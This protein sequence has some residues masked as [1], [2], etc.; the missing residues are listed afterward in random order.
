MSRELWR[1]T[2]SW[3]A[4]VA[5]SLRILRLLG[6]LP[7]P[8]IDV[9]APGVPHSF[10]PKVYAAAQPRSAQAG[11]PA[12]H[13]KDAA[14]GTKYHI[15]DK[16]WCWHCPQLHLVGLSCC[17]AIVLCL[18][19][20]RCLPPKCHCHYLPAPCTERIPHIKMYW[21]LARCSPASASIVGK[22][23]RLGSHCLFTA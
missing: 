3:D 19:A 9:H 7:C 2:L 14:G 5:L 18:N 11:I 6:L 12:E 23:F 20:S 16:K 17:Q 4:A 15:R 13:T 10:R 22:T 1:C 21:T 8:F